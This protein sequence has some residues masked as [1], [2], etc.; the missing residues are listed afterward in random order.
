MQSVMCQYL[1][2]TLATSA[3]LEVYHGYG[4]SFSIMYNPLLLMLLTTFVLGTMNIIGHSNHSSRNGH[5]IIM[6]EVESAVCHIASSFKCLGTRHYP[7]ELGHQIPETFTTQWTL[8]LSI[9]STTQQ[10]S[11]FYLEVTSTYSLQMTCNRWIGKGLHLL[12]F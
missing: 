11:I 2:H 3:T 8:G 12:C 4:M 9:F 7:Q 1:C 10:R 5:R 6:M